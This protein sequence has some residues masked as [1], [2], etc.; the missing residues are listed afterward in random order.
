MAA[1][2]DGKACSVMD[3]TGMAQK[4]GAVVTHLR[5]GASRD[6]L[7]ATRLWEN[8]VDLVIGCDLVVTTSQATLDLVRG[9]SARIVV[10]SDVVPT[11]QF[12]SN[13][14]ID[15]SQDKLLG[16][17]AQRV[18]RERISAVP[19]T[20]SA[21]R[22][23]GDSIATNVFMLGYAIQEGLMPISLQAVEQAINLN[24]VAIDQNLHALNW[25]RLAAHDPKRFGE[26]LARSAGEQAGEE[27][28][29]ETLDQLVA[30]RIRHLTDYQDA[31]YARTYAAYVDKVRQHESGRV[32]GST[33]I[34]NAVAFS[35]AKLMSYK[36]EYEVARLYTSGDFLRRL[37][38]QFDGDYRP[39]LNP[40]DKATGKPRKVSFGPWM[41]SAFKVLAKLKRLRGTAFDVFGYT[42]ERRTE[43]RL[44]EDYRRT[45]D[46][47]LPVLN[48]ENAEL[49]AKIAALPDVIRGYGHVKE[50]NLRKYEQELAALLASFD[51][52]RVAK[53]A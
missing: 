22:L 34:T 10:N 36:D 25:G 51:S 23:I 48:A 35:L 4:G 32:P 3:I 41:F 8:S 6:K 14:A 50:E 42:G 26:L 40:R 49:V 21:V 20:S 37:R 7:F 30:R 47:V 46:G 12:Q 5:F 9:D 16:V 19:A 15:L 11:A 33:V 24:G 52:V 28:M 45:I 1:H 39:I 27:P 17:L 29:S 18:P 44:I 13:Q 38:Q 2:L 53:T 31:E 43:R